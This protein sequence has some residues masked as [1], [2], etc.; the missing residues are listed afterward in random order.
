MSIVPY[1]Y[2][3]SDDNASNNRLFDLHVNHNLKFVCT[4]KMISKTTIYSDVLVLTNK[5]L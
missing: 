3:A 4:N 1:L 2:V 5:H